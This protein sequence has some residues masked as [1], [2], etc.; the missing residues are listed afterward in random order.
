MNTRAKGSRFEHEV[1]KALEKQG[2]FVIRQSCSR[3]PD[4]I[5]IG[6]ETKK[7]YF[8]E[9]KC[10]KYITKGEKEELINMRK[11]GGIAVAW[12]EYIGNK[13]VICFRDPQNNKTLVMDK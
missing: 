5:A 2:Y 7:A 3:F 8:I 1:K 10:N 13:K 9:C 11:F 6:P 12:P 4:L